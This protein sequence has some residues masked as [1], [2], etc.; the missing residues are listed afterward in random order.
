MRILLAIIFLLTATNTQANEILTDL[1]LQWG[2]TQK[3]LTEKHYQLDECITSKNITSCE[4]VHSQEGVAKGAL[5]VLFFE[6]STGLQKVQM[7]IR[8]I[9]EDSTGEQGRALYQE[10]KKHLTKRYEE[11]KS[12]EYTARK[13]YIEDDEFYQCLD[14]DGCGSWVSFWKIKN[15]DFT[16]ISLLGVDKGA[17]YLI[18]F[19]ESELWQKIVENIK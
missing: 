5:Y 16:Y 2:Q 13:L 10:L 9:T 3:E 8:Y 1:G 11:P 7:P 19:T 12:Y 4:V 14:H 15:G 18:L 6:K 17:G